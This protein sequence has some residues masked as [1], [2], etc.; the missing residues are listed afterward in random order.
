M[1]TENT[2]ATP[3]SAVPVDKTNAIP[4]NTGTTE[5]KPLEIHP[6][7][8]KP[9]RPRPIFKKTVPA[10][11]ESLEEKPAEPIVE[12][13][14]EPATTP[15]PPKFPRPRPVMKRPVVSTEPTTTELPGSEKNNAPDAVQEIQNLKNSPQESIVNEPG[16][17][18]I[19]PAAEPSEVPVVPKP[20]RPRPIFKR[21]AASGPPADTP[22][23]KPEAE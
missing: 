10:P 13:N 23:D 12:N 2:T 14:P 1:E 5:E 6:E 11:V 17:A 15:E 21:P 4:E 8:P 20:P 16:S 3:E 7:A 22:R 19:T 18:T 9:P